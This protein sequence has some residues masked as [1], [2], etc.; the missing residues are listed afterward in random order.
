MEELLVGVK[1]NLESPDSFLL[2]KETLTRIGVSSK[3]NKTLYQ[4]CHILHK[5][6][7]YYIVHFKELFKLDGKPTSISDDDIQRR[8]LI[9][10]L[11]QDW[12]LLTVLNQDQ[13]KDKANMNS[14]K[15]LAFHEKNDWS[16][17][18]K[19]TIGNK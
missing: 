12:G 4:S 11:L 19:Y 5:R 3:K 8:N 7:E 17:E 13:I 14:V 1:V 9:T 15:V 10:H 6:G 16:L 2:V 18:P